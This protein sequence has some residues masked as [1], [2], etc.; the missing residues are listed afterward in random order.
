NTTNNILQDIDRQYGASVFTNLQLT[1]PVAVKEMIKELDK[2]KLSSIDTDIKGDAFEYFLQQATAT[3]NDL[4]EYFTPRHITK[5]IV[6][7]VNPKYGEKIYD[8]FCGTGGFL[9]EAFDHIKD[10]TL[11]ANNSSEEIKLKHNTIFGREIT[12]N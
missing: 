6:N 2:L 9:T 8:P 4:G 3:N 1:N 10:N 5:T 12:S 11:I 7:L